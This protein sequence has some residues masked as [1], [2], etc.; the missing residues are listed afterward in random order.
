M[1]P[2]WRTV[3]DTL[4][5][6]A[7]CLGEIVVGRPAEGFRRESS[8]KDLLEGD[9]G[10]SVG[11]ACSI[12]AGSAALGFFQVGGRSPW[13]ELMLGDAAKRCLPARAAARLRR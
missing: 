3:E 9:E 5:V 8:V 7:G 1:P 13:V 2:R 12:C 4:A 6:L 10:G 11:V